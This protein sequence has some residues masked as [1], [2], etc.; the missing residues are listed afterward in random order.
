MEKWQC[1]SRRKRD[2]SLFPHPLPLQLVFSFL[3]LLP[4]PWMSG[5]DLQRPSCTYQSSLLH[6]HLLAVELQRTNVPFVCLSKPDPFR[7]SSRE[8][9]RS[10]TGSSTG[11]C[12]TLQSTWV[13]SMFEGYPVTNQE[14]VLTRSYQ[15]H[16]LALKSFPS[17][18]YRCV[19]PAE[20]WPQCQFQD[21][22]HWFGKN[23]PHTQWQLSLC[24]DQST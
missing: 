18:R 24:S 15:G 1:G 3:S 9:K 23:L 12:W 20:E 2:H 4:V 17:A 22:C 10:Q 7:S 13:N 6:L 11:A 8:Q 21:R 14:T 19:L 16:S 5:L